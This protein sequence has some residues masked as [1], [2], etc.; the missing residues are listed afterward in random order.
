MVSFPEIAAV[1]APNIDSDMVGT[2]WSESV[3]PSRQAA[4]IKQVFTGRQLKG[5]SMK[6]A[7]FRYDGQL[8]TVLLRG[9]WKSLSRS[10]DYPS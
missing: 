4:D 8:Y 1:E 2:Y 10:H 6:E 5:Q 7:A 9:E 3:S